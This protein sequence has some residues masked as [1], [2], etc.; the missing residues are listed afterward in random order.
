MEDLYDILKVD[1]KS[2]AKQIKDSY[3]KLAFQ[4]A[5]VKAVAEMEKGNYGEAFRS[6]LKAISY[7][8]KNLQ[9][10]KTMLLTPLK[11]VL[12]RV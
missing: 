1:K 5:W 10:W 7:D 8:W 2:T 12:K 4:Y 11:R 9:Y 3:K 6:N